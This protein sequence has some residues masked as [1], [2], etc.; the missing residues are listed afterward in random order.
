M[1]DLRV[2]STNVTG[3]YPLVV[4]KNSS[5]GS[6]PSLAMPTSS[7]LSPAHKPQAQHPP[8]TPWPSWA[9]G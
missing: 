9:L 5:T 1:K 2:T 4:A 8:T 7:P 6:A 3:T